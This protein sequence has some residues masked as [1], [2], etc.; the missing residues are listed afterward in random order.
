MKEKIE[1]TKIQKKPVFLFFAYIR[2]V[3]Y[4]KSKRMVGMSEKRHILLDVLD[5]TG[6]TISVIFLCSVIL[7]A[8]ERH[9]LSAGFGIG[10]MYFWVYLVH[11]GIHHL[12]KDGIFQY[13]NTHYLFHHQHDKLLD[14][15]VELALE[16]ITDASMSLS[17]LLIQ[18]LTGIW[19]VPISVILFYALT[20]TSTHIINYSIIGS[21]THRNH[22]KN[23]DTN[24]GPDTL[25]HLFGTSYDD[26]FEDLTPISLNA[27]GA[28]IIVF[29]LKQHFQW[30][31]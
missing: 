21:E 6:I 31:N 28:F 1:K 4:T 25:D 8:P 9:W 22:H 2:Y 5:S 7:A 23:T 26:K 17:V 24:Y 18:W 11:R 20:Y 30:K 15:R 14:R 27:I 13:T 3:S 16:T 29:W 10:F 12:P 19:L